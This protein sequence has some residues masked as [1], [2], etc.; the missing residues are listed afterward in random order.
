[1]EQEH[2]MLGV[3]SYI[4][5]AKD[6][7]AVGLLTHAKVVDEKGVPVY[8][9]IYETLGGQLKALFG[10]QHGFLMQTSQAMMVPTASGKHPELR[11]PM[12][13]L[14]RQEGRHVDSTWLKDLDTVLI[15][16]P[17]VGVKVYTYIWS[18]AHMLKACAEAKTKVVILDRPNPIAGLGVKGPITQE[19]FTSFV[20]LYP[21]AFCHAMTLGEI[22]TYLNEYFELG[23]DL[24]VA[25]MQGWRRA[26]FL[27]E[28]A[29]P[30]SNP[31]PNLRSMEALLHYPA[32]VMIEATN[33]SEGRG[34]PTPFG[35]IGAPYIQQNKLAEKIKH[36]NITGI[37]VEPLSFTPESDIYDGDVCEGLRLICTD[38]K[39]YDPVFFGC[40]L[41][42]TLAH[43]YSEFKFRSPPY[44]YEYVKNPFDITVGNALIREMISK[45]APLSEIKALLEEDAQDFRDRQ[46]PFLLYS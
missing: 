4:K 44:E 3:S 8:K 13:S 16:L 31:S 11:V 27:D 37:D 41:I 40:A 17:D 9:R 45:H 46:K 28:C 14:Y 29:L 42:W 2:V 24:E 20:G 26:S 15:D 33:V 35:C 30:W 18:I 10:P 6:S 7:G 19:D 36:L 1:M 22:A 32:T 39:T 23:C 43:M 34:T 25:K 12:Y 5:N 38:R 21:I